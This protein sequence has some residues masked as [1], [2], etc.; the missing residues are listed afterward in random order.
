VE[1]LIAV[2]ALA[3]LVSVALNCWFIRRAWQRFTFHA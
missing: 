3:L 2:L 1:L